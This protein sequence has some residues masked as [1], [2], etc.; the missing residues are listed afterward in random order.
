MST[1]IGS[2]RFGLAALFLAAGLIN[3][4]VSLPAL[5]TTTHTYKLY[6][7]N[8][9]L[10]GYEGLFGTATVKLNKP[11]SAFINFV[12]TPNSKY[13]FTDGGSVA[14][15]VNGPFSLGTI[16]GTWGGANIYN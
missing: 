6:V 3:T 5:A 10:S 9:K 12:S 14:V 8:S 4:G 2:T 1:V 13:Y 16:G 11:T 15:N 7:Y